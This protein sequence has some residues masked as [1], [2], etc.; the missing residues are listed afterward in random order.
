MIPNMNG[1]QLMQLDDTTNADISVL[2]LKVL[3]NPISQG[4]LNNN[5]MQLSQLK[6]FPPAIVQ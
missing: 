6:D 5:V 4:A 1:V 3:K 2:G